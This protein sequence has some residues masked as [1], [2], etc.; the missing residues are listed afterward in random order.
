[1]LDFKR[2]IIALGRAHSGRNRGCVIR[3]SPVRH[4]ASQQFLTGFHWGMGYPE[5]A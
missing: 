5:L 1:M 4:T 2:P 3:R